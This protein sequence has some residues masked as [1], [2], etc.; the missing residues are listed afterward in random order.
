MSYTIEERG[1]IYREIHQRKLDALCEH[2]KVSQKLI[3]SS[4][5]SSKDDQARNLSYIHENVAKYTRRV[6]EFL[7]R[8]NLYNI[9]ETIEQCKTA[10]RM[11]H[12][13]MEMITFETMDHD[14]GKWLMDDVAEVFENY[15]VIRCGLRFVDPYTKVMVTGKA[16]EPGT[17]NVLDSETDQ[18]FTGYTVARPDMAPIFLSAVEHVA[19]AVDGISIAHNEKSG[20]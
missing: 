1:N 8:A 9:N 4:E 5:G 12:V 2:W 7:K 10:N 15:R 6:N 16:F 14:F 18:T 3:R 20:Q 19:W 11:A 13:W 17:C